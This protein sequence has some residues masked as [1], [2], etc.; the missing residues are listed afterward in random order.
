MTNPS[1]ATN[2]SSLLKNLAIAREP[3]AHPNPR[4]N[5]LVIVCIVTLLLITVAWFWFSTLAVRGTTALDPIET[6]IKST[7]PSEPTSILTDTLR[8]PDDALIASILDATGY[9][10]ARRAATVSSK[11]TGKVVAVLIEEG[12][13]V[14]AGDIIARLDDSSVQA[15][16][17]LSMAQLNEAQAAARELQAQ[18][19]SKQLEVSRA[20]SL[21]QKQLVSQSSVDQLT[22]D[23]D[24]LLAQSNTANQVIRVSERRVAIH[25][26]SLDDLTIRAPFS[27]VVIKKSAQP[28][29]I[30]S[31]I[32]AGGGFTRTGIGTIVDMDSLEVEVDVSETYINRVSQHQEVNIKL[33]AYPDFTYAGRVLAVIPTAD[34]NKATIRVRV[35]FL[36]PDQKVL[37]EMGVRVEFLG[38]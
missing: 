27:G 34:R 18:I 13:A 10:V 17:R 28:G 24:T 29:E 19:H 37:P 36:T 23:L 2:T 38:G 1:V 31:P 16:Y 35:G 4:R 32:S 9:V 11:T 5:S 21:V 6:D 8:A 7:E 14:R 25:R 12:M 26:V 3:A 33:N 20:R 30:I 15:Q 22:A